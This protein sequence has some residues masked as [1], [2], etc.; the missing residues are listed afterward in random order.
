[1]RHS[2]PGAAIQL[3]ALLDGDQIRF[4]IHDQGAG[5]PLEYRHRIFERF[6][7]VPGAET[8][9]AG[10]GLY[11]ASQIVTAHEGSLGV[12]D[13][14]GG[15]SIFWFTLPRAVQSPSQPRSP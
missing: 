3:K 9:K 14:E 7:R 2:P 1:V 5:V 6:F 10:L 12:D 8:G 4:E 11:I 13:R 15:G